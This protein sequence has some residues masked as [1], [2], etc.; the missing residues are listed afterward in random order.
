M[1][2]QESYRKKDRKTERQKDRK[3]DKKKERLKK[4][5]IFSVL[6]MAF[7]VTG[8]GKSILL[9]MDA[10]QSM[11]QWKLIQEN[12]KIKE[13]K[14]TEK[15]I[16][17]IDWTK[18]WVLKK[19]S[20]SP[21]QNSYALMIF[22]ARQEKVCQD[23][24]LVLNFVKSDSTVLKEVK[25]ILASVRPWGI[26]PVGGALKKAIEI[27]SEQPA[28]RE[29]H[30]VSDLVDP[31]GTSNWAEI[32]SL[33]KE[34]QIHLKV[35]LASSS[36][37]ARQT[38]LQENILKENPNLSYFQDPSLF[39]VSSSVSSSVPEFLSTVENSAE[40]SK[41]KNSPLK[42]DDHLKVELKKGDLKKVETKL[43]TKLGIKLKTAKK[44]Y[45]KKPKILKL[46][47]R[48]R[49]KAPKNLNS[50]IHK[51]N[52]E[53]KEKENKEVF[54]RAQALKSNPEPSYPYSG[55]RYALEGR[56]VLG[57][58]IDTQGTVRKIEVLESSGHTFLDR[59]AKKVIKRWKFKPATRNGKNVEDFQK[60]SLVFR[61]GS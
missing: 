33:L 36:K 39:S 27:L 9:L 35:L 42:K 55:L 11:N 24:E 61:I 38:L 15:K 1:Y 49:N 43:K 23:Y 53:K 6:F 60:K 29:I 50:L 17:W 12:Q 31:C 40:Q 28:P 52:K 3:I 41:R 16:R 2:K 10:S 5:M 7:T 46:K 20:E 44:I 8:F 57:L 19:I 4:S 26:S 58:H 34:K 45:H 18:Q 21:V 13:V 30:L 48:T 37:T 32:P 54:Q 59:R 14:K 25:M 47:T 51:E 56:V 22:G